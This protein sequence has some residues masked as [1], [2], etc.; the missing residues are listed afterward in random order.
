M[1][2]CVMQLFMTSLCMSLSETRNMHLRLVSA[3][4]ILRTSTNH[5]S[6]LLWEAGLQIIREYFSKQQ[7]LIPK[8]Y[9]E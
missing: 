5:H 4:Q 9:G 8:P 1:L 7:L 2:W 3:P 6:A